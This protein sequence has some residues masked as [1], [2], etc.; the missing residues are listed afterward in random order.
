M[1]SYHLW[2]IITN[3]CP[4]ALWPAGDTYLGFI[5]LV[6]RQMPSGLGGY[7]HHAISVTVDA[8]D[9]LTVLASFETVIFSFTVSLLFVLQMSSH[10]TSSPADGFI[11]LQWVKWFVVGILDRI[12]TRNLLGAYTIGRYENALSAHCML[13]NV[14]WE[15]RIVTAVGRI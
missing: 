1:T 11:P 3:P 9:K 14:Q 15:A 2:F 13:L 6:T 12:L 5:Q 8:V 7:C 10:P 4:L